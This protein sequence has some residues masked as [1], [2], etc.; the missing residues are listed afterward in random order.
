MSEDKKETKGDAYDYF[1]KKAAAEKGIDLEDDSPLSDDSDDDIESIPSK[2]K[3][4]SKPK[5]DEPS[6]DNYSDDDPMELS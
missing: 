1:L 6:D 2:K 5:Q 4:V 3:S